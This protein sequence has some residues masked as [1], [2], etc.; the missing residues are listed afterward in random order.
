[1]AVGK[2]LGKR[3]SWQRRGQKNNFK[4]GLRCTEHKND[5]RLELTQARFHW[6]SFVLVASILPAFCQ[7]RFVTTKKTLQYSFNFIQ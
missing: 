4:M 5:T 6:R 1:M 3:L 2:R 7:Q